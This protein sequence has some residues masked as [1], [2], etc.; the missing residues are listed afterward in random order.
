MK[1]YFDYEY[2]ANEI[3]GYVDLVGIGMLANE[4]GVD[5]PT[6]QDVLEGREPSIDTFLA[7]ASVLTPDRW[8]DYFVWR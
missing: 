7:L 6:I 8:A 2:F 3:Q 5:A 4:S 1:T